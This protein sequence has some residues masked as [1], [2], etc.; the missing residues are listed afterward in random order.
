MEGSRTSGFCLKGITIRIVPYVHW[1]RFLRV[2][3]LVR[4]RTWTPRTSSSAF[5]V[6]GRGGVTVL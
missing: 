4:V 6:D 5:S 2:L 1:E 3:R